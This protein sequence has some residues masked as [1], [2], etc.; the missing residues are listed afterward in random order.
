M[1]EI[2]KEVYE[3]SASTDQVRKETRKNRITIFRILKAAKNQL[4]LRYKP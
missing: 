4:A 3:A 1:T 2:A